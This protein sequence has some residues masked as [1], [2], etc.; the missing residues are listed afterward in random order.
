MMLSLI[1]LNI[2]PAE[3]KTELI[4]PPP[5]IMGTPPTCETLQKTPPHLIP[6]PIEIAESKGSMMQTLSIG[7]ESGGN[8]SQ[9]DR[10]N[11]PG[12]MVIIFGCGYDIIYR[13]N[14]S[15]MSEVLVMIP[16]LLRFSFLPPLLGKY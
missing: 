2:F 3:L 7:V 8:T 1:T 14:G 9:A 15:L 16:L 13:Q 6:F 5:P 10:K 4:P 11:D 12:V